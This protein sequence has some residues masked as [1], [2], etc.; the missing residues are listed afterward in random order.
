L[1]S[2]VFIR[3][4]NKAND[5]IPSVIGV[6]RMM[7]LDR[8]P[9]TFSIFFGFLFNADIGNHSRV[10]ALIWL[11]SRCCLCGSQAKKRHAKTK[12]FFNR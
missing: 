4:N 5:E 12:D 11:V 7:L 6:I 10:G 9:L 2:I 3:C 1:I 8:I